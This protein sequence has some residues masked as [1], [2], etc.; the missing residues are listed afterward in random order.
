LKSPY[1]RKFFIH[2][3]LNWLS[4]Y[5]Q[6]EG[7]QSENL[8]QVI[9]FEEF[10]NIVMKGKQDNMI[11]TLFRESRKYGIGLVAIDQTPSE[12][13]NS[14]FANL[15]VK[16][17]F[18]LG[19]TRDI[20][21]MAKAMNLDVYQSKYVKSMN[22]EHDDAALYDSDGLIANA[23]HFLDDKDEYIENK[24]LITEVSAG[25]NKTIYIIGKGHTQG[26]GHLPTAPGPQMDSGDQGQP[27]GRRGL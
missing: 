14:I 15:N 8:R 18:A 16:V 19:T 13:P 23:K 12:I 27:F 7:I 1:D 25:T 9:L 3:I 4:I 2:V 10:H 22:A 26:S 24:P 21:E 6:H 17:S 20:N 5:N 11:S